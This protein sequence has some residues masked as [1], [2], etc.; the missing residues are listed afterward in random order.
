MDRLVAIGSP[1][2]P[3]PAPEAARCAES[4]QTPPWASPTQ[5]NPAAVLDFATPEDPAAQ[6]QAMRH[7]IGHIDAECFISLLQT[8]DPLPDDSRARAEYRRFY[9][10]LRE[11]LEVPLLPLYPQH[12]GA[13]TGPAK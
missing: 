12:T 5:P 4:T 6:Q 13:R 3:R 9:R 1:L 7:F 2:P 8:M 10:E 11:I